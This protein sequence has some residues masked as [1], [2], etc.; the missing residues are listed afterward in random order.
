ME[1]A[2]IVER[3]NMTASLF[4]VSVRFYL[5]V[6]NSWWAEGHFN[7]W[8]C[9]FLIEKRFASSKCSSS[10]LDQ[11]KFVFFFSAIQNRVYGST[12]NIYQRRSISA[13]ISRLLDAASVKKRIDGCK[14]VNLFR[15]QSLDAGYILNIL[16]SLDKLTEMKAKEQQLNGESQNIIDEFMQSF[17]KDINKFVVEG[18]ANI[19]ETNDKT[20]IE[21][22]VGG[23]EEADSS[24]PFFHRGNMD[25]LL[26]MAFDSYTSDI[27]KNT[28]DNSLIAENS[29]NC[30]EVYTRCVIFVCCSEIMLKRDSS[31]NL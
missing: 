10:F 31:K 30:Y 20:G 27:K 11:A 22:V 19:Y 7:D 8:C 29:I 21:P 2:A 3:M 23:R 16:H 18:S 1:T 26:S 15:D 12:S 13:G 17:W 5:S 14:I 24:S 28:K 25:A 6:F 9:E 4:L